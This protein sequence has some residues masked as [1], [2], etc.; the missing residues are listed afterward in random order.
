METLQAENSE[1]AEQSGALAY[2]FQKER[3]DRELGT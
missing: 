2:R 1:D 3:Q